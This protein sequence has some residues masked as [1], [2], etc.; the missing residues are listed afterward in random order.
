MNWKQ[1]FYLLAQAMNEPLWQGIVGDL[2]V[3]KFIG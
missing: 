2:K 3:S 1:K